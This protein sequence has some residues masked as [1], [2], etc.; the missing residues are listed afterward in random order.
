M[1]VIHPKKELL[2]PGHELRDALNPPR[3]SGHAGLLKPSKFRPTYS[4]FGLREK[5]NLL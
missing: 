5:A 3:A 1:D 4:C 2:D